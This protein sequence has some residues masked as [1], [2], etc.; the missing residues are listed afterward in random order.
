MKQLIAFRVLVT[1]VSNVTSKKITTDLQKDISEICGISVQTVQNF[2]RSRQIRYDEACKIANHFKE[3]T[4]SSTDSNTN[5]K[6]LYEMIRDFLES[7]EDDRTVTDS[8]ME[9]YNDLIS[10]EIKKI[11]SAPPMPKEKAYPQKVITNHFIDKGRIVFQRDATYDTIQNYLRNNH[12]IYLLGSD[13][14]GKTPFMEWLMKHE[15]EDKHKSRPHFFFNGKDL[16][17]GNMLSQI[18]YSFS[19]Q[20]TGTLSLQKKKDI[21][22]E[23]FHKSFNTLIIIDDVNDA[24][25]NSFERFIDFSILLS[26]V[27][28]LY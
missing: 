16:E 4:V 23:Y 24:D 28:F 26:I 6:I 9:H 8:Y 11:E 7:V 10:T 14:S 17:I 12:V 22:L 21:V 13:G 1:Y 2:G 5:K 27:L 18:I 15:Q 3:I 25:T 19:G 20:N